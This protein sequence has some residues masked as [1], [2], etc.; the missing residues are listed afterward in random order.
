MPKRKHAQTQP[1]FDENTALIVANIA[2]D[3]DEV[4]EYNAQT[5][6]DSNGWVFISETAHERLG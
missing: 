3:R 6:A 4:M 1:I 5:I 2:F